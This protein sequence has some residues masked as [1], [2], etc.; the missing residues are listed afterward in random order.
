MTKFDKKSNMEN[1]IKAAVSES[2]NAEIS[3]MPAED[4]LAKMYPLSAADCK[5][6][7]EIS[8]QKK[9]ARRKPKFTLKIAAG[10][11]VLFAAIG[12]FSVNATL[13][14]IFFG[15]FNIQPAENSENSEIVIS[16]EPLILPI[17]PD[18]SDS[19]DLSDLTNSSDLSNLSGSQIL[20]EF[21]HKE[22]RIDGYFT[23]STYEN[24]LG[25]QIR[26]QESRSPAVN[27][28]D[29]AGNF[30]AST[31]DETI[32]LGELAIEIFRQADGGN[33]AK[34]IYGGV[35]FQVYS[36]LSR[37]DILILAEKINDR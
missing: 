37:S 6:L 17:F 30:A 4:E 18:L 19:A 20:E 7:E 3:A 14:F 8:R 28:Q 24:N 16:E 11:A 32:F 15:I 22:S 36:N 13:D 26:I 5:I 23:T 9:L 1:L 29:L 27:E 34:W 2:I 10:F 21:R 33:I 31:A 35:Q 25:E 12:L